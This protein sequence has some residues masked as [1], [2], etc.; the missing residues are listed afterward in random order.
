VVEEL[1]EEASAGEGV[2]ISKGTLELINDAIDEY[3]LGVDR[4]RLKTVIRELYVD[5]LSI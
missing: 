4:E 5:S 2:D 1:S 3:D